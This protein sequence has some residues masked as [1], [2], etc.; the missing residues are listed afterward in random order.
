MTFGILGAL[1]VW[2]A[3]LFWRLM[4]FTR[5]MAGIRYAIPTKAILWIPLGEAFPK[6]GF[7]EEVWLQPWAHPPAMIGMLL[8]FLALFA[9]VGLLPQRRGR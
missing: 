9:G 7:Y 8:V 4:K 1:L 2:G 3:Y 6:Y 5:V